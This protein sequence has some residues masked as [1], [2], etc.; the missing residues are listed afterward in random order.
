MKYLKALIQHWTAHG[1]RCPP[2]ASDVQIARFES[3]YAVHL[4]RDLRQYFL[5]VNGMGQKGT[6]DN[7]FYSFWELGDVKTVAEELCTEKSDDIALANYF[8]IADHSVLLPG[9]AIRLS[10][11]DIDRN[12]IARVYTDLEI[13]DAFP[14][15]A[16]FVRYYLADPLGATVASK[17][18]E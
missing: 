8:L 10:A 13:G 16:D 5:T 3:H 1:I 9:F 7:D 12:P 4:P 15:F 18:D 14:S 6:C 2:G 11:N 17:L